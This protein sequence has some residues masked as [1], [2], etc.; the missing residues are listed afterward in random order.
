MTWYLLGESYSDLKRPDRAV[1]YYERA[2]EREPKFVPAVYGLGVA[3]ARLGRKSEF[4]ATVQHLK[5]LD[6][7]A[8]QKLAATPVAAR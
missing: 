2:V 4:D 6:P 1:G 8:A 5:K 3:Y 7:G